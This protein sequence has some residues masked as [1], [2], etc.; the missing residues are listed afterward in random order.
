M[1]SAA[2]SAGA[3]PENDT[4]VQS[5]EQ[6]SF[7]WGLAP[8][9]DMDLKERNISH[10][11]ELMSLH[12][13]TDYPNNLQF[14]KVLD[15]RNKIQAYIDRN[16]SCFPSNNS[17]VVY[18]PN[19][20]AESYEAEQ[21]Y[22]AAR[23]SHS[24][25]SPSIETTP[26]PILDTSGDGKED[27]IRR[28]LDQCCPGW[29]DMEWKQPCTAPLNSVILTETGDTRNSQMLVCMD[30]RRYFSEKEQKAMLF[31]WHSESYSVWLAVHWDAGIMELPDFHRNPHFENK[32]DVDHYK[33]MSPRGKAL[34]KRRWTATCF[35][36]QY[37]E[38]TTIHKLTGFKEF[39]KEK[40]ELRSRIR[41]DKA[42]FEETIIE[43][44]KALIPTG[45]A[46]WPFWNNS[47]LLRLNK[48]TT[49]GKAHQT[50]ERSMK[51]EKDA[52]EKMKGLFPG[53]SDE[54]AVTCYA[55]PPV[56]VPGYEGPTKERL[57]QYID[58]YEKRVNLLQENGRE[59]GKLEDHI[60]NLKVNKIGL[61]NGALAE[62]LAFD[63]LRDAFI[64]RKEKV[65][66]VS[67]W[68][69]PDP[70][71]SPDDAQFLKD[72]NNKF[73]SSPAK[74]VEVG[75]S[76]SDG[77]LSGTVHSGVSSGAEVGSSESGNVSFSKPKTPKK[78]KTEKEPKLIDIPDLDILVI[79]KHRGVMLFEVKGI[80][81]L[82]SE[83]TASK[84]ATAQLKKLL[85][86]CATYFGISQQHITSFIFF[87]MLPDA[88]VKMCSGH[89]VLDKT[90]LD[91]LKN[92][93]FSIDDL[94]PL[95]GEQTAMFKSYKIMVEK[96]VQSQILEYSILE[97]Y[98]V[99]EKAEQLGGVMPKPDK[100]IGGIA[101]L[102]AVF[103]SKRKNQPNNK[104]PRGLR[105]VS[106]LNVEQLEVWYGG[107]QQF[108]CGP[109]GTGK[110]ILLQYK[111][112]ELL[113][114]NDKHKAV[115]I[116]PPSLADQYKKFLQDHDIATERYLI[117]SISK[118]DPF[119][120]EARRTIS[121]RKFLPC[122]VFIDEAHLCFFGM[123]KEI[124]LMW[125]Y[126]ILLAST[127]HIVA[128]H[129]PSSSANVDKKTSVSSSGTAAE[130]LYFWAAALPGSFTDDL[131]DTLPR[132]TNLTVSLRC[133][134]NLQSR[135]GRDSSNQIFDFNVYGE[136]LD[137][138][139]IVQPPACNITPLLSELV[140][141]SVQRF[142]L[143]GIEESSIAIITSAALTDTSNLKPP[144]L[145]TLKYFT[146][147]YDSA[148]PLSHP[149]RLTNT[150]DTH[151]LEFQA[152]VVICDPGSNNMAHSKFDATLLARSRGIIGL[153]NIMCVPVHPD[154]MVFAKR[155]ESVNVLI[156][157]A[158]SEVVRDLP[159]NP[160]DKKRTFY[161]I[162]LIS[163]TF[164]DTRVVSLDKLKEL[165]NYGEKFHKIRYAK[166]TQQEMAGEMQP[167][168]VPFIFVFRHDTQNDIPLSPY[169]LQT[170]DT[171]GIEVRCICVVF[172]DTGKS[173]AIK[174]YDGNVLE[175]A[176]LHALADST[177]SIATGQT[178][179]IESAVVNRDCPKEKQV[180]QEDG[181]REKHEAWKMFLNEK[182]TEMRLKTV[183]V[184]GD[185][186]CFYR[187][188]SFALHGTEERHTEIRTKI[189]EFMSL[190]EN[191]SFL[192][193]RFPLLTKDKLFALLE[194]M[195]QANTWAGGEQLAAASEAF[196]CTITFIFPSTVWTFD[197]DHAEKSVFIIYNGVDHYMTAI[198]Q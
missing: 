99:V 48:Q 146:G 164:R 173:E 94:W 27:H 53:W 141:R 52:I 160:D 147:E 106:F 91:K 103:N 47:T 25:S 171:P 42:E 154:G 55:Y 116:A 65:F 81:D 172:N 19:S 155:D 169:D 82:K 114:K 95:S 24:Q 100:P 84:G 125:T 13:E 40:L 1:A 29:N 126:S 193:A 151:S 7:E 54:N 119:F 196:N 4:P 136:L 168:G 31:Y 184:V 37:N 133:A 174:P 102:P 175:E 156:Y 33:N 61:A 23:G 177:Y 183:D 115:I 113:Q 70:K 50:N 26:R 58:W 135:F 72:Y 66:I 75:D 122:H 159:Y 161:P 45:Y 191:F 90:W 38:K 153:S 85:W 43:I 41:F 67:N 167:G 128:E 2:E 64:L 162:L 9:T 46:F 157:K 63:A 180:H 185:G 15:D 117:V 77:P 179:G 158:A 107:E 74:P 118:D 182:L 121:T 120:C 89:R 137:G 59:T 28:V 134:R 60:K 14:I 20:G 76:S 127:Q 87:P 3:I 124:H 34:L 187:A 104:T 165:D 44:Y 197:K 11:S 79:H 140:F 92:Q 5:L 51:K 73:H 163:E 56:F 112:L 195:R 194:E 22:L 18:S 93:N 170:L 111:C 57:Q 150:H 96:I 142:K 123:A 144:H 139:Y 138:Q 181:H 189:L 68:K 39:E 35:K 78:T 10:L 21:G 6:L 80:E 145:T 30:L 8:A 49:S 105:P 110:T 166:Y 176:R 108:I 71:N 192:E 86:C 178:A 130:G 198:P 129:L 36:M 152:A 131:S 188:M 109:A 88:P 17:R 16:S 83:K 190:A 149:K 186:N 98:D 97:G 132:A 69:F 143:L 148:T 101:S 12:Q 32:Q 62:Y